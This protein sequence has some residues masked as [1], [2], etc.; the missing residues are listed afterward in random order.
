MGRPS[1]DATL[2]DR[3]KRVIRKLTERGMTTRDIADVLGIGYERVV[4]VRRDMG[5][6]PG[7]GNNLHRHDLSEQT[8]VNAYRRNVPVATIAEVYGVN[9]AT[10]RQRLRAADVALLPPGRAPH[11]P[12]TRRA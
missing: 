1:T 3:D 6:G 4:N 10:I 7:S 5:L 9:P 11:R 12:Y 8:I 2:S